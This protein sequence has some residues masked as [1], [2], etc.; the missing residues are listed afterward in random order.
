MEEKELKRTLQSLVDVKLLVKTP[1]SVGDPFSLDL[2]LKSS[3]DF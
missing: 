1:P 2:V 3:L